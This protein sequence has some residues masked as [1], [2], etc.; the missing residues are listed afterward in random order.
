MLHSFR[1]LVDILTATKGYAYL[2]MAI[3]SPKHLPYD[4]LVNYK[5]PDRMPAIPFGWIFLQTK[6]RFLGE[7]KS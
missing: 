2:Q 7:S 6:I 4:A 3:H 5:A 1:T